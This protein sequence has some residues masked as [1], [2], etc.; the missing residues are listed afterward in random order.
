MQHRHHAASIALLAAAALAA[1]ACDATPQTPDAPFATSESL[2]RLRTDGRVELEAEVE[3]TLVGGDD[4]RSF[5]LGAVSISEPLREDD[6]AGGRAWTVDGVTFND[7]AWPV[8]LDGELDFATRRI[9]VRASTRLANDEV[10]AG[11]IRVEI[12]EG[13]VTHV[14][15]PAGPA[16]EELDPCAPLSADVAAH[17]VDGEL[18][19]SA[20]TIAGLVDA[21][22]SIAVDPL[23]RV[24][25]AGAV[26][27]PTEGG[28]AVSRLLDA[29]PG[30]VGSI[31]ELATSRVAIAPGTGSGPTLTYRTLAGNM[32]VHRIERRDASLL[33]VWSHD[34]GSDKD[35]LQGPIIA[36]SGG[37]V[38]IGVSVYTALILD[39]VSIDGLSPHDDQLVLFDA[40]TGDFITALGRWGTTHVAALS[41]GS[42]AAAGTDPT[43]G[44]NTLVSLAP[45]LTAR[46]EVK[47][48]QAPI[49]L[50]TTPDDDVW[51][52]LSDRVERYDPTGALVGSVPIRR[53]G[54]IVPLPDGGVLVGTNGGVARATAEGTWGIGTFREAEVFWCATTATWTLAPAPGGAV[55]VTRPAWPVGG[56]EDGVALI[57]RIA[58]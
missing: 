41:A 25:V 23:G 48:E 16:R 54:L 3:L 47:L 53:Q 51:V 39:G 56:P 19:W 6:P 10:P 35:G 30:G 40:T 37:H 46:W 9:L 55:F 58:L 36:A 2:Y 26:A 15:T 14:L 38:L 52:E 21:P 50:A 7:A 43:S 12:R 24:W 49:D 27:A 22:F 57:G 13:D 31:L 44:T 18:A 17:S 8:R 29:S 20:S 1:G 32:R 42:F 45:D 11:G 4:A 34:I 5:D 33:P 28:E